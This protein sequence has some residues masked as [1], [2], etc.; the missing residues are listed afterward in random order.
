MQSRISNNNVYS[1]NRR[2]AITYPHHWDI[3][4]FS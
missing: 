4:T 3:S 2:T 1:T